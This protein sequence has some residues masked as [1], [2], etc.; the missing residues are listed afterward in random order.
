MR[1]KQG[2]SQSA[3]DAKGNKPKSAGAFMRRYHEAQLQRVQFP[4]VYWAERQL[5]TM[6]TIVLILLYQEIRE[7][8]AD[9][10]GY[11]EP[12][13]LIFYYLPGGGINRRMFFYEDSP[14]GT[15]KGRGK[16]AVCSS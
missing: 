10:R 11:I 13:D 12:S 4:V 3:R 9:W 14:L 8:L 16:V 5:G 1:R 15:K 2:G 7:L 6:M